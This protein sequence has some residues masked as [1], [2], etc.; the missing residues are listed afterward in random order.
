[1]KCCISTLCLVV[2]MSLSTSVYAQEKSLSKKEARAIAVEI[3]KAVD[4]AAESIEQLDWDALGKALNRSIDALDKH[5]DAIED[6]MANID[7]EGL[8]KAM[9][10]VAQQVEQSVPAEKLEKQLERIAEHVEKTLGDTTKQPV[11]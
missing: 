5:S 7:L 3:N 6:V 4:K 8:G 1:M 11:K 2:I 10:K 9:E